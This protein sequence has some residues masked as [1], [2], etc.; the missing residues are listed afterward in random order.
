LNAPL[1]NRAHGT[2]RLRYVL[3]LADTSLVLAQRLGEWVGHAPALE[4]ELGLANIAL[5]L[6]GQ[7]R[8][9][10]GYAGEI[11]ACGRSEDDLAF[12][13]D[14]ADFRNFSLVEQPNGDFGVTIVREVLLDA[15]QLVLYGSLQHSSD[16]RLAAIAAKS[17]KETRYHWR[18]SSGWLV[19]LG[20]G[21]EES[22]ERV[23]AALEA[24][25]RFTGELFAADEVDEEMSALRIAPPLRELYPAWSAHIDG[26]LRDATLTRPVDVP[27]RWH[28]KRGEHSEHLGYL[29]AD[30]QFLYRAHPG[31]LW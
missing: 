1:R 7:A 27:Y 19:R 5:D 14:E 18:Y 22:H 23:E 4:E 17:L 20:D 3:R 25:W 11:E 30:M 2:A 24:L 28:G 16:A 10:F 8:L 12:S 26:V 6:L 29:L 9:F 31:A 21:T 15:F 13:R